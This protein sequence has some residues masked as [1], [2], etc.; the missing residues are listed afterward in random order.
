MIIRGGNL[1]R[2]RVRTPGENLIALGVRTN[3][4]ET[5]N[6]VVTSTANNN[7]GQNS[8]LLNTSTTSVTTNN[9]LT[10][11]V[12]TTPSTI[13]VRLPS[14]SVIPPVT[15]RHS[16][17]D[18]TFDQ[19]QVGLLPS[20][21][22]MN[23]NNNNSNNNDYC[24]FNTEQF[25]IDLKTSLS[26]NNAK[27]IEQQILNAITYLMSTS[28]R[29][30]QD[31]NILIILSWLSTR[32]STVFVV[33]SI[34]KA[35]CNLLKS[36]AFNKIMKSITTQ[37]A[38]TLS[39]Q[40][41]NPY[42]FISQILWLTHQKQSIWPDE[43]I[44]AYIDDALN[45]HN[46][47][48]DV[49]CSPF[50]TNILT[51]FDTRPR[52]WKID[53]CNQSKLIPSTVN[54]SVAMDETS[55]DSAG[56]ETISESDMPV[57]DTTSTSPE[58]LVS[59]RYLGRLD[60][61]QL[62]LISM[63]SKSKSSSTTTMTSGSQPHETDKLLKLLE[64]SCGLPEIRTLV[65]QRL[66]VWLQNPKLFRSAER[67]LVALCENI[68]GRNVSSSLND[69]INVHDK[70]NNSEQQDEIM[71]K[72]M[73][74]LLNLRFKIRAT[75]TTK[76]FF[77]CIREMLRIETKL[78]DI[79][80]RLIVQNELQLQG[81]Q[82]TTTKNPSNMSLLQCAFQANQEYSMK[83]LAYT[84]QT[85]ILTQPISKQPN[86]YELLKQLRTFLRE[87]FRFVK[88]DFDYSLF[89]MNLIDMNYSLDQQSLFWKQQQTCNEQQDTFPSSSQRLLKHLL[90]Y[91]VNIRE[92]FFFY[93]CDL[94]S[95]II[96]AAAILPSSFHSSSTS[97]PISS[98]LISN[99]STY[100]QW[101]SYIQ[102]VSCIQFCCCKFFL[103]TVPKLFDYTNVL[104]PQRYTTDYISCLYKILFKDNIDAYLRFDNWPSV[105]QRGDLFRLS[106]EIPQLGETLSLLVDI[107]LSQQTPMN[108]N[109]TTEL[110]ELILR[111]T[112]SSEQ[113]IIDQH[114]QQYLCLPQE[115]IPNFILK[116]FELSRY[117]YL[118]QIILPSTYHPPNLA[119]TAIYW[120]CC[121]ICLLL[122]SQ[123]TQIF[124]KYIWE[125]IVQ[126]R[127][128]MEMLLTGDYNYP[129]QSWL[130]SL[131]NQSQD[132]FHM[133]ELIMLQNEEDLI[134]ELEQFLASPQTITRLN[135]ELLGKVCLLDQQ[136]QPKRPFHH[137]T[138]DKS[139]QSSQ[140]EK[141]FY[142]KI[143]ALNNQFKLSSMLCRCR[144]PDY[145]L[146]ILNREK[147]QEK[148]TTSVTSWLARLIDSN[149]DCL[150]I[151]PI[152]CLC[153]YFQYIIMIY[154]TAK[155]N[156]ELFQRKTVNDLDTIIQRFKTIINNVKQYHESTI[157]LSD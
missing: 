152:I 34:T 47:I 148:T 116:L 91:D 22:N 109:S 55:N 123:N 106:S 29:Q 43:F 132:K 48:D 93:I 157:N 75:T 11:S 94:I 105:E 98:R 131:Q 27:C 5:S 137:H 26:N 99:P 37:T 41:V 142:E 31:L 38:L 101:I 6:I 120:K 133:N 104:T 78:I 103:Y 40:I 139:Q 92:R 70:N 86:E 114:H 17:I 8:S 45:E 110:I 153:E 30:L 144:S 126:V 127:I 19:D 71:R 57:D 145:I 44:E 125:N 62:L 63:I 28:K 119:V 33:P 155:T 67:L 52:T 12:L 81:Q 113:K 89:C 141:Q 72:T 64:L 35:L 58:N 36:Q 134:L 107:G 95:M 77:S 51:A 42:V 129:P 21:V 39:N 32:Q 56:G 111:R 76:P 60:S 121:L 3:S 61:I 69:V 124:G 102:R 122:A 140:S 2:N 4:R 97:L 108:S 14:R 149:I 54:N 20:N 59:P 85:I 65:L 50:V 154:K 115:I 74:Q 68:T 10:T 146:D 100:D 112:L 1:N 79:F 96:L 53:S 135:S 24:S 15:N 87:L 25:R 82:T 46:W 49:N 9:I 84:V 66:D 18:N 117:T 13:N 143:Q 7:I 156:G 128:F 73:E 150:N 118:Q 16:P 90:D 23:N 138:I 151:F 83:L 80:I 147:Q 88:S 136:T 130:L